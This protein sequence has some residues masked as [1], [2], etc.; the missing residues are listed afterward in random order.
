MHFIEK[1]LG[2]SIENDSRKKRTSSGNNVG[3][4]G[5]PFSLFMIMEASNNRLCLILAQLFFT[6][7]NLSFNFISIKV[8]KTSL[9]A[10]YVKQQWAQDFKLLYWEELFMWYFGRGE[11]IKR[12]CYI[13]LVCCRNC[14]F[15]CYNCRY[16][17][18][19]FTNKTV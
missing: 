3:N 7:G 14:M 5:V 12:K 13:I 4:H 8:L 10:L 11:G 1:W 15:T 2:T 16:C 17:D 19:F 6:R 18:P 9:T